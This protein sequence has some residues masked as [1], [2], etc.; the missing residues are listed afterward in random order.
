VA[1]IHNP[2][3]A[4][5][6]YQSK[7]K[8]DFVIKTILSWKD[9]LC[10]SYDRKIFVMGLIYLMIQSPMPDEIKIRISKFMSDISEVLDVQSKNEL[11]ELEKE[12]KKE[13]KEALLNSDSEESELTEYDSD[14][15]DEED[16]SDDL[17]FCFRGAESDSW[18]LYNTEIKKK[19]E[20]LYFKDF[21]LK[22][23]TEN[24]EYFKQIFSKMSENSKSYLRN[25]FQKERVVIDP[26]EGVTQARR[27]V[28]IKKR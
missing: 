3:I 16:F 17:D 27:I 12:K 20:F 11:T 23:K 19:D 18:R 10:T 4:I 22:F 14:L 9:N 1:F 2:K 26:T 21:I 8:L 24:E 25:S 13:Q 28:K 5:E 7:G 15:D 6:Y